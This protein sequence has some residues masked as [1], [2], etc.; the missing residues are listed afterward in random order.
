MKRQ[1]YH[2]FECIFVKK[3]NN[4]AVWTNL[5]SHVP[6][7]GVGVGGLLDRVLLQKPT[8]GLIR[9]GGLIE[10]GLNREG[11]LIERGA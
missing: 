10:R 11:G 6:K 9:E 3:K 8:W 1:H 5:Q 7:G 2:V 4:W